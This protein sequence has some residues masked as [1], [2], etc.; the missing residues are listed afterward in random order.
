MNLNETKADQNE[1]PK[2][3]GQG[4]PRL[5]A[6]A[7]VTGQAV[8]ADDFRLPRHLEAR[9]LRSSL[10]H[11]RIVSIDVEQ[12][13][14][15]LGVRAVLTGA[16][17]SNRR[18]GNQIQDIPVLA[19][20]RV[21]YVGEPLAAVAAVDGD[22][23][24]E[25]LER[26]TVEYEELPAVF[27][28]FAAMKAS[29]PVLHPQAPRYQGF[30][31][32]G[33]APNVCTHTVYGQGNVEEGLAQA[34][35]IFED[36]F[37]TQIVHQ[38]YLEPHACCVELGIG[39]KA[40]LWSNHKAPFELRKQMAQFLGLDIQQIEVIYGS[41]GGDF[42]G[43]GVMMGEPLCY[44]LAQKS[45]CPVK[46]V[47]KFREELTATHTRHAS[48]ITILSGLNREGLV[49][50]RQV[51]VVFD[52]GAYAGA[53]YVGTVTGD[54]R[55]AGAYRI[56][57]CRIDAYSVYTNTL[58]AG[59]CRAPGDPQVAFAVESH[60]DMVAARMGL[61]PYEFRLRNVLEEGD[62]S[63][64]GEAWHHIL[65]RET[66]TSAVKRSN[67]GKPRKPCVGRGLALT[68]RMTG[69]GISAALVMLHMDGSATLMTGTTDVGTGSRTVLAQIV[70]EEL[71]IPLEKVGLG[72]GDTGRSPYDQGSGGSRV[73]N[74]AGRAARLAA[75]DALQQVKELAA[76]R[77]GCPLEDVTYRQGYVLTPKGQKISLAEIITIPGRR[78]GE[79]IIGRAQNV[80]E[81]P[82]V[83]C[84]SA[85]VVEVEV[86][87]DT[88]RV[89]V[90]EVVAVNDIGRALNPP[91]AHGQV[92]GAVVQGIGF[93]L[94]EELF[95]ED[96]QPQ[97]ANLRDYRMP[98]ALDA[99]MVKS[100]FLEDGLGPGPHGSKSIGEQGIA[101]TAPAIANAIWDAVGVRVMELPVT[102][103]KV[104]A[105]LRGKA[106]QADATKECDG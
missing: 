81:K 52:A 49:T 36:T 56:P 98:T 74:T 22:T 34:A 89:E 29:A 71:Q 1:D 95:Y 64:T 92:E 18:Y 21:R 57:H 87:P 31:G 51:T 32:E 72:E 93:A 2:V 99:P 15:L 41:I 46:L 19:Y 23:A 11:A 83:N 67:W 102:P 80:A 37:H 47:L 27:D 43:K 78:Q 97:V 106:A 86:D 3:I 13:K 42:G 20:D 76:R 82:L 4:V 100:Y 53:N 70:A 17:L 62:L 38:G 84:F 69:W 12:A 65:A 5:D 48:V 8:Y 75:Q 66:L 105:A 25:A 103:E 45:G 10:P 63:P 60:T 14:A 35:F 55:A 91:A 68:E 33:E 73:T 90:K 7:K 58:P 16:D 9:V 96:G 39:G 101:A 26:I 79:A 94:H 85:Q 50:A 30:M 104:R 24:E 88:G 61:D 44:L 54:Q 77:L 28:P 40:R 6:F 59:H